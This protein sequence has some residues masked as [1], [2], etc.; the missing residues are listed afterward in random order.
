MSINPVTAFDETKV[1]RDPQGKFG[2]KTGSAPDIALSTPMNPM[3]AKNFSDF[4]E[5]FHNLPSTAQ[6]IETI[7]ERWDTWSHREREKNFDLVTNIASLMPSSPRVLDEIYRGRYG[8]KADAGL[9]GNAYAAAGSRYL[10]TLRYQQ[11]EPGTEEQEEDRHRVLHAAAWSLKSPR[12]KTMLSVLSTDRDPRV[13]SSA[14]LNRI[15]PPEALEKL[16]HD[17]DPLVRE[18]AMYNKSTPSYQK[19]IQAHQERQASVIAAYNRI[20]ADAGEE[21]LI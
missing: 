9:V 7:E 14:A 11:Q 15:T 19:H 10:T 20:Q 16:V 2:E 8:A 3:D 17:P 21:Q 18:Y 4:R 5:A 12:D 13:R 6:K 1:V